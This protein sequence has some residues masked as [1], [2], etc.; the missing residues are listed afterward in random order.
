MKYIVSVVLS[1]RTFSKSDASTNG[2]PYFSCLN[3]IEVAMGKLSLYS[4]L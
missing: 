2:Y 3:I 4:E 1:L